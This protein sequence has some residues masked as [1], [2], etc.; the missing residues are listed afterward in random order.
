MSQ[1]IRTFIREALS[2]NEIGGSPGQDIRYKP[3]LAPQDTQSQNTDTV[4]V[5]VGFMGSFSAGDIPDYV[6]VADNAKDSLLVV[7]H[8]KS[9][10]TPKSSNDIFGSA[11]QIKKFETIGA[12]AAPIQFL[13][14]LSTVALLV[15]DDEGLPDSNAYEI[16]KND[17]GKWHMLPSDKSKLASFLSKRDS[18]PLDDYTAPNTGYYVVKR[19]KNLFTGRHVPQQEYTE[20]FKRNMYKFKCSL[21]PAQVI[22]YL[23]KYEPTDPEYTLAAACFYE[24][25]GSFTAA[26][27]TGLITGLLVSVVA[28]PAVGISAGFTAMGLH[29]LVFR[30]VVIRWAYKNNYTNFF[31]ANLVY[32]IICLLF[33]SFNAF[34]ALKAL[35]AAEAGAQVTTKVAVLER[36]FGKKFAPTGWAEPTWSKILSFLTESIMSIG[37][38][39]FTDE[40]GKLDREKIIELLTNHETV[41]REIA[42]SQETLFKNAAL[43]FPNR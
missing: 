25:A 32:F 6:V 4:P 18:S 23:K 21:D 24:Y 26:A 10:Y 34:K 9:T 22:E 33:I 14:D 5:F 35:P 42:G 38:Y 13:K 12:T 28:T 19:D 31:Y 40:I 7:G 37:A 36:L 11:N 29:D 20:P 39:I 8:S 2:I 17:A 3:N 16:P 30:I 41:E 27:L 15:D 43:K 1:I